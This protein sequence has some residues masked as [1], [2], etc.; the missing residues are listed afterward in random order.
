MFFVEDAV[1]QG[2]TEVSIHTVDAVVVILAV[3]SL[4][5]ELPLELGRIFG[6]QQPTQWP[7]HWDLTGVTLLIFLA[8]TGCDSV[9]LW[10]YREQNCAGYLESRQ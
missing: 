8:F 4:S 9:I 3:T 6:S 7:G 5:W 10:R 1:K 2:C